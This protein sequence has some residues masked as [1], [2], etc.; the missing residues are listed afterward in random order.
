MTILVWMQVSWPII[1][2]WKLHL[3][4]P[5][6]N[7]NRQVD[8]RSKRLGFRRQE[9]SFKLPYKRARTRHYHV[10]DIVGL[11]HKIRIN[12]IAYNIIIQHICLHLLIGGC[13]YC[14]NE[15]KCMGVCA[16]V[17]PAAARALLRLLIFGGPAVPND[18]LFRQKHA[19]NWLHEPWDCPRC[20]HL[21][22][23]M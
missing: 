10:K 3:K 17:S 2:I 9:N 13:A 14:P 1:I 12:D 21:Q 15:M 4:L 11:R 18:K 19:T 23:N 5:D 6:F 22:K 7:K 8:L 16:L 20:V